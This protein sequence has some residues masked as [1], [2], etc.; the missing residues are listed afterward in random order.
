MNST[1]HYPQLLPLSSSPP[2]SLMTPSIKHSLKRD[3][4]LLKQGPATAKFTKPQREVRFAEVVD[5][6]TEFRSTSSST[7][8]QAPPP[9]RADRPSSRWYSQAELHD[10]KTSA[11]KLAVYSRKMFGPNA[12]LPRGMEGSAKQ[13]MEHRLN[14]V[15]WIVLAHKMGKGADY[16]ADLSRSLSSWNTDLAF[17]DACRDY[18]ESYRPTLAHQVP[19]VLSGPPK[20]AMVPKRGAPDNAV[21]D[22]NRN[23]LS[24]RRKFA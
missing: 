2:S 19:P 23:S 6:A 15:R 21:E 18:L 16:T 24:V 14:T 20:I 5:V 17:A 11:V 4:V 13:R 22:L 8:V 3:S 12:V 7:T 9:S 10:F 1:L